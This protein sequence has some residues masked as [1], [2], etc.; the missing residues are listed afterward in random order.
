MSHLSVLDLPGSGS[1]G[2]WGGGSVDTRSQISVIT[3]A[4]MSPWGGLGAGGQIQEGQRGGQEDEESGEARVLPGT[5][6][7]C[8]MGAQEARSCES[9]KRRVWWREGT[10]TQDFLPEQVGEAGV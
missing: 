4:Q 1:P 7:D 6:P 10:L 2:S 3:Q 8:L 5:G 9:L